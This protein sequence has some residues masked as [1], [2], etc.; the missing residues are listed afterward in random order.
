VEADGSDPRSEVIATTGS[1]DLQFY[2]GL[3][4]LFVDNTASIISVVIDNPECS[5]TIYRRCWFPDGGLAI[6][7]VKH[8]AACI[9]IAIVGCIGI[10]HQAR[11]LVVILAS[12]LRYSL[13]APD[14]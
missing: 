6:S 1:D 2:Y 8:T 10:G 5:L 4:K 11:V 13:M 12:Q 7:A 9:C 14:M 3:P